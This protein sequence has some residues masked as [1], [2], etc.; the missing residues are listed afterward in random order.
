[1]KGSIALDTSVLIEIALAT[2]TGEELI[3]K[4]LSNEIRPYTTTMNIIELEYVLCRALNNLKEAEKRVNRIINSKYFRIIDPYSLRDTIA[5]CKC[6]FPISLMDCC[7][8]S[9][10]KTYRIPALFYR[11]EKE[12]QKHLETIRRWTGKVIFIK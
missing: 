10:A 11:I 1:L 5:E 6:L 4:I 9:L 7:S 3:D 8:L 2:N 12:F